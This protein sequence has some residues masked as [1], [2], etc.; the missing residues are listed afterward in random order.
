MKWLPRGAALL[1]LSLVIILFVVVAISGAR[2]SGP[3]S[4]VRMDPVSHADYEI[5]K[6]IAHTP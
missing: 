5:H 6:M 1:A 3:A 4:H 2:G